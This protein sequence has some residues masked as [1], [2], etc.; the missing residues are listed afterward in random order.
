MQR[1]LSTFGFEMHIMV[2]KPKCTYHI[3]MLQARHHLA[4]CFTSGM[5][6]QR[7]G[8][9]LFDVIA[10]NPN[11]GPLYREL[12]ETYYYWALNVPSEK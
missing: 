1:G 4:K 8:K 3:V 12:A 11:Y 7:L 5:F 6:T 10:L 2:I 9:V